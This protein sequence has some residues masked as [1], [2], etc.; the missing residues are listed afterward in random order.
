ML[1]C[2]KFHSTKK[3][4]V[5]HLV[6]SAQSAGIVYKIDNKSLISFEDNYQCFGDLLFVVYFD[7]ETCTGDDLFQDKKMYVFIIITF[8]LII[9]FHPKLG[10]E[11]I[12]IFRSFQQNQDHLFDLSHLKDQMLQFV[13]PVT[14]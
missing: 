6:N 7:F 2:H 9:A 12:V 14:S 8:S 10:I 4:F 3:A 11:R 1:L 13:D 5:K